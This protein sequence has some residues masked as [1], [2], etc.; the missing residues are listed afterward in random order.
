M[1]ES[2]RFSLKDHLFNKKSVTQL[3]DYLVSADLKFPKERF[4]KKVLAGFKERELKERIVWMREQIYSFL[5]K[6]YPKALKIILKALPPALD[7]TKSDDDFGEFIIAPLSDFV[8][9]YGCD[10]KNLHIS[11]GALAE[12][13]KRFSCEDAIRYFINV[14][15]KQTLVYLEKWAKDSNYHVRRLASEGT[16]P[17]LP[18]S[19]K[20]RYNSKDTLSLLNRLYVDS[21]RYVTRSVANHMN[22]ISKSDP[23]L[24]IRTL[25]AWKKSKKQ[26]EKE[27]D[28]IINHS[29]RTLVKQGNT[30]ALELLGF[31]QPPKITVHNFKIEK[32]KVAV[33]ETLLFSFDIHSTQNQSL[34]VDY[35]I[36]FASPHKKDSKKVFKIKKG[37]LKKGE[38]LSI[39]KKHPL[40]VMTTRRL[41]SGIHKV[42]LQINGVSFGTKSFELLV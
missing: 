8:A 24:I 15:P 5:P 16:R 34:L 38:A 29:L 33:G 20:I 42:E 37:A 23:K 25:K 9:T 39:T 4:V 41:Y 40:R 3:A 22:D 14:F 26:N 6:D 12:I 7:P 32:T 30:Q 31:H 13:T 18:W 35:I 10:E 36:H 1:S 28:F 21:T 17:K 27:I 19:Q 11:L 2:K